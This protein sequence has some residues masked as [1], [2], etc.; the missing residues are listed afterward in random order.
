MIV[1]PFSGNAKHSQVKLRDIQEENF[2]HS[3]MQKKVLIL[4]HLYMGKKP[5]YLELWEMIKLLLTL[6][7]GQSQMEIG[8]ST[9]KEV[10]STNMAEC[11]VIA[12]H[13]VYEG[14]QS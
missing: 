2:L 3:N 10:I 12:H 4:S 11:S 7:H 14:N 9:N 8:F 6:S 1:I 5:R 13:R